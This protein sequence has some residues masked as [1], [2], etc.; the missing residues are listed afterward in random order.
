M[1]RF[2]IVY[3]SVALF[4]TNLLQAQQQQK[5]TI[6]HA[7]VFLTGAELENIAKVHLPAGASDVL[8]TNIAGEIN[9][10]SI[11]VGTDNSNV[12]IQSATFQKNYLGNDVLSPLAQ[13]CKDSIAL[14]TAQKQQTQ[15]KTAVVNEQIA[16]LKANEKVGGNNAGLNIA[17]LQKMLELV[18]IRMPALLDEKTALEAKNKKQDELIA[19]LMQQLEQE[20]S[21]PAGQ[22]SVKFYCNAPAD[23][24]IGITYVA[25]AASW[26]PSYD[27]RTSK[28]GDPLALTY[29]AAIQQ[30]TGI[31]WDNVKLSIS[32]GNPSEGASAP[33]FSPAYLAFYQPPVY[34]LN[35]SMA[36]PNAAMSIGGARSEGAYQANHLSMDQIQQAPVESTVSTTAVATTYDIDLPYTVP[37]DGQEHLVVINAHELPAQYH[38]YAY[39]K[40]DHDAFL[41]AQVTNWEELNLLPGNVNIFYSGAYVGQSYL[42]VRNVKDTLTFSLGRDKKIIV[43]RSQDT[44]MRSVKTIGSNVKEQYAY[45]ITVRNT[46]NQPVDLIIADQVPVSSDKDITVEDIETSGSNYNE[47]TGEV[48]WRITL[49]ANEAKELKLGYTIKYPK[50]KTLN[51]H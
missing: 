7:T 14:V 26:K 22:V 44:K 2:T 19:K 30:S 49:K 40:A 4:S 39:P 16:I 51:G 6:Q 21:Q 36:A 33:V 5:V 15:N 46:H 20:K 47:T 41:Q 11:S 23:A 42:D 29:K 13:S 1:Y 38:Y 18:N 35:K 28:P 43:R 17:D 45:T 37:A 8:F 50:G 24:K 27:I 3:L 34:R 12:T 9:T 48:N 32:T 10:E 31:K 25:I